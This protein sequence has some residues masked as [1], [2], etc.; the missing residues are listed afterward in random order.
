MC[1]VLIKNP[2]Y[3]YQPSFEFKVHVA[4]QSHHYKIILCIRTF[5]YLSLSVGIIFNALMSLT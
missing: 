5:P 4:N 1:Q 3:Q 2:E